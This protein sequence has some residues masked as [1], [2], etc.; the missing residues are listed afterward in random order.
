MMSTQ[1]KARPVCGHWLQAHTTLNGCLDA[2]VA[3]IP[4][5]VALITPTGDA[6][7]FA[8]LD[9]RKRQYLFLLDD[10]AIGPGDCVGLHGNTSVDHVAA[11]LAIMHRGAVAVPLAADMPPSYL[12]GLLDRAG[13]SVVLSDQALI[14]HAVPWPGPDAPALPA[15][16]VAGPVNADTP[17]LLMFTSGSTGQPKGV[18][19][20]HRQ[21]VNRLRW[22]YK[23]HPLRAD[24]VCVARPTVSIMP[25]V[26]EIFGGLCDGRPTLILPTDALRHPA[27][28]VRLLSRS[29]ATHMTVTPALLRV[30]LPALEA[31]TPSERPPLRMVTIG[32]EPLPDR[33]VAEFHRVLPDA[34]LLEDYGATET[35]TIGHGLR[36]EDG[37]SVY[38]PIDGAQVAIADERGQPLPAGQTG[39]L[40]VAG[41]GLALCYWGDT[42]Q[43]D[44]RFGAFAGLERAY[45]TGDRARLLPD[46]R[47]HLL[48]RLRDHV[49][50]NGLTVDL[51]AVEN[52]LREQPGID[53]AAAFESTVSEETWAQLCAVVVA[54]TPPPDTAEL[55][56]VLATMLPPHMVPTRILVV[57]DLP[58]L[59]NGKL[60]R[61]ALP[62]LLKEDV[63]RPGA[64]ADTANA[65]EAICNALKE[66]CGH[67]LQ[68]SEWTQT[69]D[70]LGLNSLSSV[71][72]AQAL[73]E[74]TEVTCTATDLFD[75]VTP[76]R[77]RR[78][79]DDL[80][81][82]VSQKE[83]TSDTMAKTSQKEL[84]IT[85]LSAEVP[86]AGTL[87]AFWDMIRTGATA[88]QRVAVDRWPGENPEEATLRAAFLDD[89]TGLNGAL[90]GLSPAEVQG[91]DPQMRLVLRATRQCL[92]SAGLSSSAIAGKRIGVFV[93][94]RPS[95]FA[96]LHRD[97]ET[98]HAPEAFLGGDD[99][100]IAARIAHHY[101][102]HGPAIAINTTCSSG[103]VALHQAQEAIRRGDCDSAIVAAVSVICD[104]D[105]LRKTVNLGV[106]SPSGHCRPFDAR[107][108]GFVPSEG[109]G[110]LYLEAAGTAKQAKRAAYAQCVTSGLNHDGLSRSVTAP[111]GHAQA[112]L[113]SEVYDRVPGG[114]EQVGYIETH[115][116][117]TLLG[118][119][120]EIAALSR[121]ARSE[122]TGQVML[123]S[124]K[125]N[126]GHANAAAGLVGLIKT[127]LCLYHNT[128]PPLAG[129]QT[130]NPNLGADFPEHFHF[131][132]TAQDWPK[133]RPLAGVSAFGMSG[134]NA[135]VVLAPVPN[136]ADDAQALTGDVTFPV[137][138]P[139][140]EALQEFAGRLDRWIHSTHKLPDLHSMAAT[141][142]AREA[143]DA[144]VVLTAGD[145]TGVIRGLR[146]IAAGQIVP[147][148]DTKPA[149]RPIPAPLTHLPVSAE[150]VGTP[151]DQTMTGK[152]ETANAPEA[153]G[154]DAI[155]R[156]CA[157]F[158]G[159]QDWSRHADTP[160]RDLGLD[161][162]KLLGLRDALTDKC[163]ISISEFDLLETASL[164]SIIALAPDTGTRHPVGLSAPEAK[165]VTCPAN[166]PLTDLQTVYLTAKLTGRTVWD[167]LG[168]WNCLVLDL[169]DRVDHERLADAWRHVRARHGMLRLAVNDRGKARIAED[170][171]PDMP[172]TM[173]ADGTPDR[174]I[175]GMIA[176]AGSDFTAPF[177]H[178]H[179]LRDISADR[180]I[181]G[182]DSFVADSRSTRIFLED[183]FAFYH[184]GT[185]GPDL[186]P[187]LFYG[188]DALRREQITDTDREAAE[189]H[190]RQR[191]C[192]HQPAR[193]TDE[194][195]GE[196]AL[197]TGWSRLE[198][199]LPEAA[200]NRLSDAARAADV[201]VLTCVMHGFRRW[202]SRKGATPGYIG[203][204]VAE[205]PAGVAEADRT[206][207]P[208]TE[209]MLHP[210]EAGQDLSLRDL[211]AQL[212]RDL[213]HRALS[214]T[215][216]LRW[217]DIAP[218]RIVFSAVNQRAISAEFTQSQALSI[219]SGIDLHVHATRHPGGGM[220]LEWDIN[221]DRLDAVTAHRLFDDFCT[222]IAGNQA[223]RSAVGSG[224]AGHHQTVPL[225]R[226]MRSYQVSKLS[227]GATDPVASF[228]ARAYHIDEAQLP[229]VEQRWRTLVRD[230]AGLHTIPA[231][232]KLCRARDFTVSC[233]IQIVHPSAGQSREEWFNSIAQSEAQALAR[234][235]WPGMR[236]VAGAYEDHWYLVFVFSCHQLDAHATVVAPQL[237]MGA[238]VAHA[239]PDAA[240]DY[241]VWQTS[242]EATDAQRQYWTKRLEN[243]DEWAALACPLPDPCEP[244]RLYR[245]RFPRPPGLS[246]ED[247]A[248]R[249]ATAFQ[250]SLSAFPDIARLPFMVAG[251][252]DRSCQTGWQ[253]ALGD[254]TTFGF[255]SPGTAD[256]GS[257]AV[258]QSLCN[259]IE[260]RRHDWF[261]QLGGRIPGNQSVF[262]AVFTDGL[263]DLPVTAEPKG[264]AVWTASHTIGPHIDCLAYSTEGDITVEWSVSTSMIEEEAAANAFETFRTESAAALA[265]PSADD[266][267]AWLEKQN[268]TSCGYETT[269]T[270]VQLFD[271]AVERHADAVA[272][273]DDDGEWTYAELAA[274]TARYADAL[275]RRHNIEAGAL[276]AVRLPRDRRLPAM[277]LA[278][279]RLGA[280][281]VPLNPSDPGER[282]NRMLNRAD[283][284]LVITDGPDPQL[285]SAPVVTIADLEAALPTGTPEVADASDPE[286]LAYVI[287]TSGSTGEP[288]GVM[289]RHKP[290]I[291][292]LEDLQKR[293]N[294]GPGDRGIWVN[295]VGFDLTIFDFFGLLSQGA[296]LRLVN[297][298]D[299]LDPLRIAR[300][301][302]EE[303]I[304]F[305]NSAP[306]YFH[307]VIGQLLSPRFQGS[308]DLRLAFFSGD[309][310][311]LSLARQCLE[312]LPGMQ[313]VALGGATEAVV[314]SNYHDI[315]QV[316]DDWRSIPYG[317]P[318]QNARYYVL[319]DEL[320]PLIPGEPGDLFI[321]GACLSDGYINAP[322]LN[323]KAFVPDPFNA[324]PGALMYRTGD[325]AQFMD[326]GEIEFLG[327]AD[328][329][330][331]IRGHRIEL[332]EV[333]HAMEAA[334]YK[335]PVVL[336]TEGGQ[337]NTVSRSLIGFCLGSSC[338]EAANTLAAALPAYMTPSR[339]VTLDTYP[340][341]TNGKLDRNAL[342]KMPDT[343]HV[344]PTEPK[345]T[346]QPVSHPVVQDRDL[347]QPVLQAISELLEISTDELD[348]SLG[349][350]H[351]GFN[352]L[353]FAL[354]ANTLSD[355][356]GSDVSTSD[357]LPI[358]SIDALLQYVR[359]RTAT[360]AAPETETPS[361]AATEPAVRNRPDADRVLTD[362]DIAV[363]GLYCRMP[364]AETSG[365]FWDNIVMGRNCISEIPEARWDWQ[366]LYG[367]D[368]ARNESLSRWG[369]F[370]SH[371]DRFDHARFHISPREAAAMD[372]R[373]RLLLTGCWQL[374][375]SA[376][377]SPVSKTPRA[378]GVFL[379]V[380]GDEYGALLNAQ[381]V[382]QDQLSLLGTG[383][384]FIANRINYAMNW[385]GPSEVIDTTCSSSLVAIHHAVSALRNKDCDMAVAGGVSVLIDPGPH[386]SL[387]KVGVL[388]DDGRCKTFDAR[389]NGYVRSE[390]VGLVLLKPARQ[391][392]A[393]GDRI[394][395]VI[396][397]CRINHGGRSSAMTAP[398]V[399]AQAALVQA[400]LEEAGPGVAGL[401]LHETHGT[402]TRLGDPIEV[403]AYEQ[404]L[405]AQMTR[406]ELA[407]LPA[408]VSMN[409]L[410]SA[411]GHTE[412]AA[413]VA[414][415]IKAVLAL[416]NRTLPPLVH[417]ESRNPE[418]KSDPEKLRFHAVAHPWPAPS[419]THGG[420]LARRASISAFGFGGVNAFAVLEEAPETSLSD[421]PEFADHPL[422]FALSART[423][424]LLQEQAKTLADWLE[425]EGAEAPLNDIA[426]TLQRGRVQDTHRFAFVTH[427]RAE[428]INA[429]RAGIERPTRKPAS[430]PEPLNRALSDN[431]PQT[432]AQLWMTG[433]EADWAVLWDA[434]PAARGRVVS[435][436]LTVFTESRH[437]HP[438]LEKPLAA[439]RTGWRTLHRAA[440]TTTFRVTAR[441]GFLADHVIN[442]TALIPGAAWIAAALSHLDA[443]QEHA[444]T[445]T[446]QDVT[447]RAQL[448]PGDVPKLDVVAKDTG[449]GLKF[450]SAA[451]A[452]RPYCHMTAKRMPEQT[453]TRPLQAHG[454][455]YDRE[456]DSAAC[457]AAFSQLG[458]E[459]GPLYQIAQTCWYAEDAALVHVQMPEQ[460]AETRPP[461][462]PMLDALFQ[463]VVLLETLGDTPGTP[464]VPFHI[465]RINVHQNTG[466][467]G[468]VRVV[469]SG[470]GRRYDAFLYDAMGDL[471]VSYE[472]ISGRE[473]PK[474][475]V[476]D[477]NAV[478]GFTQEWQAVAAET[479]GKPSPA[480]V[481]TWPLQNGTPHS[482]WEA[483]ENGMLTVRLAND[484]ADPALM[485]AQCAEFIQSICQDSG[486]V[487]QSVVFSIR[488]ES[489]W[490]DALSEGLAGLAETLRLEH[491]GLALMCLVTRRQDQVSA[492]HQLHNIA[493]SGL[494]QSKDGQL[495]K[496]ALHPRDVPAPAT[497]C[498]PT[499]GA[500]SGKGFVLITGGGGAIGHQISH[501]MATAGAQVLAVG[502]TAQP[503][504]AL[505]DG[506]HYAA[507]DVTDRAALEAALDR[508]RDR[509]GP[510]RAIYHCAG[511]EPGG[512]FTRRDPSRIAE[513]LAIKLTAARHLDAVTEQDK[514]EVFAACSSLIAHAGMVGCA[515][516][517]MANR[518]MEGFITARAR[519]RSGRSV[520]FAWS[521]WPD[522]G[523]TF[524]GQQADRIAQEG[525]RPIPT[526]DALAW[527]NR[528]LAIP[529]IT[530]I[531]SPYGK[532]EQIQDR[533]DTGAQMIGQARQGVLL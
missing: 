337:G 208:F 20:A 264:S 528:V 174:I 413:G 365:A 429:L 400:T 265:H 110:C 491:P 35:N 419:D 212:L 120:V 318:I 97:E 113:L 293:Y 51:V 481:I 84:V 142:C 156:I 141:F 331:K 37:R 7:T 376:G 519:N 473:L 68:D 75:H 15:S 138:A 314:W 305:W 12:A 346:P 185:P 382:V 92:Q 73:T 470:D 203:M 379:G 195:T 383:R 510:V 266:A 375:E 409:A 336:A 457:A 339:T 5:A 268:Q 517:A 233:P 206:V 458:V 486:Y 354:L 164:N 371:I 505:R 103:L 388:A 119:P 404:A 298:E 1:D 398:N 190:W 485:L 89:V 152:P 182:I 199:I 96:S 312:G 522:G 259:D 396:K 378:S 514:P 452:D 460:T 230:H 324:E 254:F 358:P 421:L 239:D 462:V 127:A 231:L 69:W 273:V 172:L 131:P 205:R 296:S 311:P 393:D 116:T 495:Q 202:L 263:S 366:A 220:S 390:G 256:T 29:Q 109:V 479:S 214:G 260:N 118:D 144:Q 511:T 54:R 150:Y 394:R 93:G 114:I 207:G 204:T 76:E 137:S 302:G 88:P 356:L 198:H 395:A 290:V 189:Q 469:R 294:F 38:H 98:A 313:A 6:I 121:V 280:G 493:R 279:L 321:G 102:L 432:A 106:T 453:P 65:S 334:G 506:V 48:G 445:T 70:A 229:S 71:A 427:D 161:S 112:S 299:R 284:A 368:P 353:H 461:C 502:R 317:R 149:L 193:L 19:H 340:T 428:L 153:S 437:W 315:I 526:E 329:Q 474:P 300:L 455:S 23:A 405:S 31:C 480:P 191:L 14:P 508:W 94:V 40:C 363:V 200:I 236:L 43:T 389:A 523:M 435:L 67:S 370:L 221:H 288:K 267:L 415:F 222:E 303:P 385:S 50:I 145:M 79:L 10:H 46:G 178:L 82:T 168:A 243:L 270:L 44:D 291:N 285:T 454:R 472:G 217:L 274:Q 33:L 147:Q 11:M 136:E 410:K 63:N 384:S 257:A 513:Q 281:F 62:D 399:A 463:A 25:S 403:S 9:A 369:G 158:V 179:L 184:G 373:Q 108:D 64:S 476:V 107:A 128:I 249:I 21:P 218:P 494:Y 32:G 521:A 66:I 173:V 386:V 328:G 295:A 83:I 187:G 47:F 18:L 27:E 319:D 515:D 143:E 234:H 418:I 49:K 345:A 180:L 232:D 478:V 250:R 426:F 532:R 81:P 175:A 484:D 258:R 211:Q 492:E 424:D 216:I 59:V 308:C 504:F 316:R 224:K 512:L 57:P 374:M 269:A 488:A 155:A 465:D 380:T 176:R 301:I 442:G 132:E 497:T 430:D 444:G 8:A 289:V 26:W 130:A 531:A 80:Q 34:A 167:R 447:F 154:H 367:D 441:D 351:Q 140:P 238:D 171:M 91:A 225:T 235:E 215:E 36:T 516:Y 412:A 129:Y 194:K 518:A 246:N 350:A 411:I 438:A 55:R 347:R 287:F 16:H 53:A 22:M 527:I 100:M 448:I 219:T 272:L 406:E 361:R 433:A 417:F 262:P 177:A 440:D 391:A 467:E 530:S 39:E 169:P 446:L 529:G 87:E 397:A 349:L 146:Q 248:A 188:L 13:A 30:L 126:I 343:R 166:G 304:T 240:V 456:F 338:P 377:Y 509:L 255:L 196:T 359:D 183:L 3:D 420:Q 292:L 123:G 78:H 357:I 335:T 17:F 58:R 431:D 425:G 360:A 115:G 170:E 56:A 483:S 99:A 247:I 408:A 228:A 210:V 105:F 325:M 242:A 251:Y 342:L 501:A 125:G 244:A 223:E 278:I 181:V 307:A 477:S 500:G 310:V 226:A 282:H 101:D 475:E 90:H 322:E 489:I 252:S 139:T 41:E 471:C 372:P 327:R 86:G 464:R 135:H 468:Y 42:R 151:A 309:W 134:T 271:R 520:S 487:P 77:L 524:A 451:D 362:D 507:V 201:P 276:V 61:T 344:L 74:K 330:V 416:E 333:E 466:M 241:A 72:F 163:G 192:D 326:N 498:D 352:S 496:R 320:N 2:V 160:F 449:N 277:L 533:F 245:F 490:A 186:N 162:I 387:S 306:V 227:R 28:W 332:G 439:D 209:M 499:G 133:D 124:L 148:K 402:G 348:L 159:P 286:G 60:D 111:N 253:N 297:E 165:P 341:T 213:D 275:S 407:R 355:L 436:P 4:G 450:T 45:R 482:G 283:A 423:E 157:N 381:D 261:A 364:D 52:A 434:C 85:G 122:G 104:A 95:G 197:D 422:L 414:G 237:V 117:G 24:D 401:G 323:E 392:L 443:G 459:Y 525:I 503:R